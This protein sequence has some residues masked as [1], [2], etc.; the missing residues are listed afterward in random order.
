M[1]FLIDP[2]YSCGL[3]GFEDDDP[4][5]VGWP[6][7]A[8]RYAKD[9]AR[10]GGGEGEAF[11][12]G[13][14]YAFRLSPDSEN[15]ALIVHPLWNCD[16]SPRIL[17]DAID[18]VVERGAEPSAFVDTFELARRQVQVREYLLRKWRT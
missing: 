15:V 11:A 1:K 8:K 18:H 17:K 3:D 16:S 7:L 13:E 9:M 10:F 2:N 5:M 12:A 6:K 4:A 14:L